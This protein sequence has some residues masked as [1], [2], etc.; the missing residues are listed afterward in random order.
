MTTPQKISLALLRVSIGWY[1]FWAGF[2]KVLDHTWSAEGFLLHA[3]MFPGFYTLFT[4]PTILPT[5]NVLNSWG[6][7]LIGV[8][9]VVGVTVR[10][11]AFFGVLLM[12]LYYFPHENMHSFIVDDHII[13]ILG[14]CISALFDSGNAFGL[15]YWFL[16]IPFV[17][18]SPLMKKLVD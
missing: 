3:T 16:Q 18:Q 1:F 2:T 8:A 12:F 17:N 5:I 14:L 7:L 6:L 11:S 4:S 9:L 15:K 13:I 10:L